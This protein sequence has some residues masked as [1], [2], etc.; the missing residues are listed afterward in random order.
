MARLWSALVFVAFAVLGA[1]AARADD[2]VYYALRARDGNIVVDGAG[3]HQEIRV[4]CEQTFALATYG[5]NLYVA[6]GSEGVAV[7]SLKEPAHPV[8]ARQ[9]ATEAPCVGLTADASCIFPRARASSAVRLHVDGNP[10]ARLL[11]F[12]DPVR[13]RRRIN[14]GLVCVAPC[15]VRVPRDAWYVVEDA[16]RFGTAEHRTEPFT[17]VD[18]PDDAHVEV[19]EKSKPTA[20]IGASLLA[21]SLVLAAGLEAIAV[22]VRKDGP[23]TNVGCSTTTTLFDALAGTTALTGSVAGIV[24]LA[25]PS[26]RTY[27][28]VTDGH[29]TMP[30]HGRATWAPTFAASSHGASFGLTASF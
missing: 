25:I 13:A 30:R 6:C 14:P 12:P 18:A 10:G 21:G 11:M 1:R 27:A 22:V 20:A 24:L 17:L 4:A 23:C 16:Q 8:A 7:Y 2:P 9:L 28:V 29:G 5:G 26:T 19:R 3:T 15:D